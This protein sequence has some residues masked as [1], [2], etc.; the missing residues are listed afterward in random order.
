MIGGFK[1]PRFQDGRQ[2]CRRW[3]LQSARHD[4][5]VVL[6]EDLR[7][8]GELF[9]RWLRV[10]CLRHRSQR[11]WIHRRPIQRR[12][13]IEQQCLTEVET[14]YANSSLHFVFTAASTAGTGSRRG[15]F[16]GR[17]ASCTGG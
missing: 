13:P 8:A 11:F 10:T 7:R 17:G 1:L 15:C 14:N 4:A 3:N 9:R 12:V 6:D 16:P 5:G 2:N